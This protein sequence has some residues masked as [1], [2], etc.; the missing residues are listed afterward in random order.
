MAFAG[1]ESMP[2]SSG[3]Q[4]YAPFADEAMR[5]LR[6]KWANPTML[7]EEVFAILQGKIPLKTTAVNINMNGTSPGITIRNFGDVPFLNFLNEFGDE[8]AQINSRGQLVPAQPK[9]FANPARTPVITWPNPADISED[10]A[11]SSTQLNAVA[12]D[13]DTGNPVL[14]TFVYN[15]PAGTT[16]SP[17]AAQALNVVFTPSNPKI[18][19]K[20]TA[21]AHIN[22]GASVI[23]YFSS[24]AGS[25]N[26][27]PNTTVVK[28][29]TTTAGDLLLVFVGS[30]TCYDGSPS[31]ATGVTYSIT[32]DQ[33]NVYTQ[34]GSTIE[35]DDGAGTVSSLAAFWAFPAVAGTVTLTA[36]ASAAIDFGV[37]IHRLQNTHP[38]SPIA[39]FSTNSD[40]LP[41]A[42]VK[43]TTGSVG[44]P[45]GAMIVATVTQ[46]FGGPSLTFAS[47]YTNG[48]M[49][50]TLVGL[51]CR[52]ENVT[53]AEA[54]TSVEDAGT[55]YSAIGV[56]IAPP[57]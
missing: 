47:P 44:A 18:Y 28:N 12:T 22:V 27:T 19:T 34:V 8:V 56:A 10:E 25:T 9:E 16:L 42:G 2:V 15:P 52:H 21:T 48:G 49:V 38:S 39:A 6:E 35:E 46:T 45:A 53:G 30:N 24:A 26:G 23:V 51:P 40:H 36:T 41:G 54:A 7:A 29:A 43:A 14:G 17:G 4:Q 57:P 1:D 3:G 5:L 32:D 50:A 55:S 33:S 37:V 20:A 31:G 11:L 13:A